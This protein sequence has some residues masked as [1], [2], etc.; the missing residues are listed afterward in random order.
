MAPEPTEH[1][2]KDNRE[3]LGVDLIAFPTYQEPGQRG[4]ISLF[5]LSGFMILSYGYDYCAVTRR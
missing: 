3:F 2:N 1:F 4:I 5:V